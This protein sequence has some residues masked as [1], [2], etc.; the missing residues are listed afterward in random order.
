L[1]SLSLSWSSLNL[2]FPG[3]QCCSLVL[4]GVIGEEVWVDSGG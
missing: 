3:S 1:I 2:F 4:E